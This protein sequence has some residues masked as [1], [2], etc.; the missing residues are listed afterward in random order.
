MKDEQPLHALF[1]HSG[2][3]VLCIMTGG[4]SGAMWTAKKYPGKRVQFRRVIAER[5]H[6]V[7]EEPSRPA[8]EQ[9][10]EPNAD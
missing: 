4:R 8:E 5:N 1:P 7:T 10:P 2:P 9:L 6:V 3:M